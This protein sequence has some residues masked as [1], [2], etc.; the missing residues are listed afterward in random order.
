MN[1]N[2]ETIAFNLVYE[3]LIKKGMGASA[4][5]AL[6]ATKTAQALT[7][8]NSGRVAGAISDLVDTLVP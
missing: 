3:G 5:K 7:A 4:A 6:A 8:M 2:K 1:I